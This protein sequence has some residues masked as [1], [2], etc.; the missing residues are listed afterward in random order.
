M[1]D[2]WPPRF[3][4]FDPAKYIQNLGERIV[5]E[6]EHAGLGGHP[7][8][9]GTARE[10][11]VRRQLERLMQGFVY[12]GSGILIDTFAGRSNQQDI[13]LYEGNLCP[14]Y[15]INE[16]PDATFFPIEGVIAVGEVKSRLDKATLFDALDKLN[17]ARKLRRFAPKSADFG[18]VACRFRLYGQ[19]GEYAARSNSEFD[20]FGKFRDGIYSFLLCGSFET[21]VASIL[22]NMIAY[23]RVN[24]VNSLPNTIVSLKDGYIKHIELEKWVLTAASQQANGLAFIPEVH[25]GFVSLVNSLRQH[26]REGRTVPLSS[27]DRYLASIG[28]ETM[29]TAWRNYP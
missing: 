19:I 12:V 27:Y 22:D 21:G 6:F 11:P 3:S 18:E 24:G 14:S 10:N 2:E 7:M 16:T 13:V 29:V 28:G 20:Q 23:A 17:S 15:S 1:D 9:K 8:F 26:V 5:L 4:D 25:K